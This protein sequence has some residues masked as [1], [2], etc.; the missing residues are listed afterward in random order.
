MEEPKFEKIFSDERG[1]SYRV[2]F[3]NRE[4]VLIFSKAGAMRG[5]HSHDRPETSM[6]LTGKVHYWKKT[7]DGK[8]TEFDELPGEALHNEPGEIHLG[9]FLEDSWLI[10]W[11]V[12]SKIGEWTTTNYAPYR[13]R[14][15]SMSPKAPT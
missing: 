6:L 15:P 5:G 2:V 4:L 3:D 8:E 11:K 9:K 14:I 10:D 13:D 1:A 7:V 12:D